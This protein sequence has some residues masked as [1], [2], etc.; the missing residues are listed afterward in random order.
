MSM[1]KQD[2]GQTELPAVAPMTKTEA[3]AL[4][5]RSR[6]GLRDADQHIWK[7]TSAQLLEDLLETITAATQVL[8][9]VKHRGI[10]GLV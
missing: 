4:I 7:G 10:K 6:E 9:A 1:T 5:K 8:D 3:Y 2:K